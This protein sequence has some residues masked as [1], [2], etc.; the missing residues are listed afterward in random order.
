[1]QTIKI[2]KSTYKRLVSHIEDFGETEDDIINRALDK[3]DKP[4][5]KISK[6]QPSTKSESGQSRFGK[7]NLPDVTFSKPVCI[8][9]NGDERMVNDWNELYYYTL[10][11]AVDRG[12]SISELA[13]KFRINI[14]EVPIG[15]K[16]YDFEPCLKVWIRYIGSVSIVR[17]IRMIANDL[18]LEV[19]LAIQWPINNKAKYSGKEARI[20][21]N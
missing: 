11:L 18:D 16:N 6:I 21:I 4:T 2:Q 15:D 12:Y 10:G 9:V 1:M 19:E 17:K 7:A 5:K 14:S 13:K 20:L 3:L 8:K